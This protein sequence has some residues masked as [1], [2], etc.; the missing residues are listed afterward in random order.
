MHF[1]RDLVPL[2]GLGGT[3]E[4]DCSSRRRLWSLK[5]QVMCGPGLG[6]GVYGL[7]LARVTNVAFGRSA[8]GMGPVDRFA[9]DFEPGTHLGEPLL[10]DDRDPPVGGGT[11]IQ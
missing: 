8:L 10:H 6:D 4:R 11:D 3:Q 7:T 2:E 1:A 9:I 5:H